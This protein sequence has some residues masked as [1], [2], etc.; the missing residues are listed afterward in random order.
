MPEPTHAGVAYL[1]LKAAQNLFGKAPAVLEA[2]ERARVQCVAAK[3]Y[4]L[5]ARVLAAPEARDATVPAPSLAAALA[6]VRKR[7]ADEADFHADLLHNGLDEAGFT[8]ALERELMVEAILEKVG[9][10]AARVSDIDVELYYQYHPDQFHRPEIRRARHILVTINDELPDNTRAAAQARIEAIAARLAREPQRFEE[11]AMK[12]SE[13][14]TALQGGLLGEVPIG[15]LYPELDAALFRMQ[16]GEAS[17][18]LESPMGLHL[19][20]C[21]AI[22]QAAVLPLKDARGPIRTLLEQRRKRVCQQAWVNQL[23]NPPRRNAP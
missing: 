23:L 14:P 2:S 7:Y 11:Q 20:R 18:I 17:E 9:T 15:Q 19:L 13:C 3:Q 1:E 10:R 21:E 22:T 6:E 4:G 12:H 5:E 8:D 16:E